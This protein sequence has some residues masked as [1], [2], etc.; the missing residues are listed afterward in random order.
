MTLESKTFVGTL[1][2]SYVAGNILEV[3][4]FRGFVLEANEKAAFYLDQATAVVNLNS[5]N[6]GKIPDL[7]GDESDI[8][9]SLALTKAE[10]Q[11]NK[12]GLRFLTRKSNTGN[13]VE[14]AEFILL[15]YGRKDYLDLRGRL[16]YPSR[17]L[18]TSDAIGVQLVDYGDGLL[19][20]TDV[21]NLFFGVTVDVSKKNDL[22]E[23]SARI[24]SLELALEGKLINLPSNTL[25]GRNSPNNGVVEAISQ[26][27]FVEQVDLVTVFQQHI[28]GDEHGNYLT[29]SRGDARYVNLAGNQTISGAKTFASTVITNGALSVSNPAGKCFFDHNGV[30]AARFQAWGPSTTSYGLYVFN[31]HYSD[32][33]GGRNA[34]IGN[35]N[36]TWNIG[37]TTN[38]DASLNTVNGSLR[39]TGFT[40]L[41]DNVGIKVKRLTGVTAATQGASVTVP[42]GLTGSKIEGWLLKITHNINSGASEAT[43]YIIGGGYS[44]DCSHNSASFIVTNSAASSTQILSKPYTILVFY[45]A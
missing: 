15:N 40:T 14:I 26:T 29:N 17:L 19:W 41:G 30:S 22:T 25:L 7:T 23:L 31:Q 8:E 9:K 36:G 5:L 35:E 39:T 28:N 33:T 4:H 2:P 3:I 34:L 44:V 13:W 43:D 1:S 12:I 32:G 11:S 6:I 18:E 45:T 38:T 21:I 10:S 42:H 24:A 37:A 20:D 27:Q 16:G